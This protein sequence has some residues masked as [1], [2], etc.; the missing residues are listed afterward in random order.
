MG[1]LLT[2]RVKT[3]CRSGDL[4]LSYNEGEIDEWISLARWPTKNKPNCGNK[5][6]VFG[7]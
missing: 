5:G 3:L 7:W 6:M 1:S 4:L 2:N